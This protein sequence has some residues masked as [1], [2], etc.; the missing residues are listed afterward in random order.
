MFTEATLDFPDEDI[1]FLRAAD[2]AGR[3]AALRA[4]L[5]TSIAARARQG[6]LLARRAR[7]SCW[8]A[9]PTSASRAC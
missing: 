6:A 2:A 8:S 7:R 1:D 3:L 4:A 9:G 5:A